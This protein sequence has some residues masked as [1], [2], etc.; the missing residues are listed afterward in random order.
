MNEFTLEQ[1]IRLE[2]LKVA[3][4]PDQSAEMN[5]ARLDELSKFVLKGTL[6]GDKP[7]SKADKS[8]P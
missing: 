8:K 6:A 2:V 5:I 1:K 4:R 7:Q 3:H